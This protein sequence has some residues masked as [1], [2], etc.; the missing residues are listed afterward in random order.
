[1]YAFTSQGYNSDA[2][3][4]SKGPLDYLPFGDGGNF[5]DAATGISNL[6]YLTHFTR[7]NTSQINQGFIDYVHLDTFGYF[8]DSI[9]QDVGKKD[10][11]K[12]AQSYYSEVIILQRSGWSVNWELIDLLWNEDSNFIFNTNG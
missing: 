4:G 5:A 12:G 7:E 1:M 9:Q 8:K 3:Q 11:L 10:L 2:V 6:G